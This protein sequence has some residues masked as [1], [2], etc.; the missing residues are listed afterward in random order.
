MAVSCHG[1]PRM[2]YARESL[3]RIIRRKMTSH[4]SSPTPAKRIGNPYLQN[5]LETPRAPGAR[6]RPLEAATPLTVEISGVEHTFN[7]GVVDTYAALKNA[8]YDAD[9]LRRTVIAKCTS[10]QGA[11]EAIIARDFDMLSRGY[12]DVNGVCDAYWYEVIS[13]V[14]I[15]IVLSYNISMPPTAW[16]RFMA[17]FYAIPKRSCPN[18]LVF[19]LP[20]ILDMCQP[21]GSTWTRRVPW[22]EAVDFAL[23]MRPSYERNPHLLTLREDSCVAMPVSDTPCSRTDGWFEVRD[24]TFPLRPTA[25]LVPGPI[26]F[27]DAPRM[28]VDNEWNLSNTLNKRCNVASLPIDQDRWS[29]LWDFADE[30]MCLLPAAV[31][32]ERDEFIQTIKDGAKRKRL[33]EATPDML[34]KLGVVSVKREKVS[35]FGYVEEADQKARLIFTRNAYYQREVGMW[36]KAFSSQIANATA[37]LPVTWT[38][39]WNAQ[40][41]GTI[42]PGNHG[43]VHEGD[44]SAF[45]ARIAEPHLLLELHMY[46][47]AGFSPDVLELMLTGMPT[48]MASRLGRISVRTQRRSGDPNTSLGNSLLNL[49]ITTHILAKKYNLGASELMARLRM[50]STHVYVMGDDLIITSDVD[51]NIDFQAEYAMYGLVHKPVTRTTGTHLATYLSGLFYPTDI[52]TV[53]GPHPASINKA[54]WYDRD[55]GIATKKLLALVKGDALARR[56]LSGF[57][58]VLGVAAERAIALCGDALAMATDY[59]IQPSPSRASATASTYDFVAEV[60]GCSPQELHDL[61]RRIQSS[62]GNVHSE[63]FVKSLIAAG[64][65][66]DVLPAEPPYEIKPDVATVPDPT[67]VATSSAPVRPSWHE[68]PCARELLRLAKR[69]HLVK[70]LPGP[71]TVQEFTD[72]VRATYYWIDGTPRFKKGDSSLSI[73]IMPPGNEKY[74]HVEIGTMPGATQDDIG[75]ERLRQTSWWIGMPP[76]RTEPRRNNKAVRGKMHAKQ[77]KRRI[78]T[79]GDDSSTFKVE[80]IVTTLTASTWQSKFTPRTMPGQIS[81][82]TLNWEK[83]SVVDMSLRTVSHSNAFATGGYIFGWSP[84]PKEVLDARTYAELAG[85]SHVIRKTARAAGT[86]RIDPKYL[87]RNLY[88]EDSDNTQPYNT[89]GGQFFYRST[90]AAPEHPISVELW[91]A[92]TIRVSERQY[93]TPLSD[94]LAIPALRLFKPSVATYKVTAGFYDDARAIAS[95]TTKMTGSSDVLAMGAWSTPWQPL[96]SQRLEDHDGLDHYRALAHTP[97]TFA[98]SHVAYPTRALFRDALRNAMPAAMAKVIDVDVVPTTIL[99]DGVEHAIGSALRFTNKLGIPLLI[100]VADNVNTRYGLPMHQGT[101][102]GTSTM[103]TDLAV[104]YGRYGA[105]NDRSNNALWA[106]TVYGDNVADASSSN[107]YSTERLGAIAGSSKSAATHRNGVS[108]CTDVFTLG[109]Y[110]ESDWSYNTAYDHSR[111]GDGIDYINS[112]A[113]GHVFISEFSPSM[114]ASDPDVMTNGITAVTTH[115]SAYDA[116]HGAIAVGSRLEVKSAP[117]DVYEASYVSDLYI[118]VQPAPG[119][120]HTEREY[121]PHVTVDKRGNLVIDLDKIPRPTAASLVGA[122]DRLK[123][124][125]KL[126]NHVRHAHTTDTH[127]G[128]PIG[129]YR[130]PMLTDANRQA[131]LRKRHTLAY[132]MAQPRAVFATRPQVEETK[133]YVSES[134]GESEYEEVS[135]ESDDDEL[136]IVNKGPTGPRDG[137]THRARPEHWR[138]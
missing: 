44:M 68:A 70:M 120:A 63:L 64:K 76:K 3:T 75:F 48:T 31:P 83:W 124:K 121:G 78:V 1:R 41:L 97:D 98:R 20:V 7:G 117:D 115:Q 17:L 47:L 65:I 69:G 128:A 81:T 131:Q 99:S 107:Y 66:V 14:A 23:S 111:V 125:R 114:P 26:T 89:I 33:E 73:I 100:T 11:S 6:T 57:I 133:H 13:C 138:R 136:P 112:T 71:P 116:T 88:L 27:G 40:Q 19:I 106:T 92:V 50:D 109:A 37:D 126:H 104:T 74:G 93:K 16:E 15:I 122:I 49:V 34:D 82:P 59:V 25:M 101:Y 129:L 10:A 32:Y 61:E 103:Y 35:S 56:Q 29:E 43:Y 39:G 30:F 4:S 96:L 53:W 86:K 80:F 18:P 24:T 95:A 110:S 22:S 58:P 77:R 5:T 42:E 54:Y 52:G 127:R 2:W 84:D 38:Y 134:S 46:R 94:N 137:A 135:Y 55:H 9:T 79:P 102:S 123:H 28:V 87:P 36:T 45:D 8:K 21:S 62:V 130:T 113:E 72:L 118:D 12:V 108:R 105:S 51:L 85:R 119:L 91:L 90:G 60:I 67:L 132:L